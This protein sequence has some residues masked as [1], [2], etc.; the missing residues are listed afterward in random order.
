V[1]KPQNSMSA[2]T[3]ILA[4]CALTMT[5][6]TVRHEFFMAPTAQAVAPPT[7][8][9]DW[10]FLSSGGH[11][12]GD[13]SAPVTILEFAD[14][15][16]AYCRS[17]ALGALRAVRSQ[18]GKDVKVVF[19][20]WPLPYHHLAYSAARAA[21]CAASQGR[22]EAYHDLL[23]EHQDSLG[24]IAFGELA[25]RA[26]VNDSDAFR[27]CMSDPAQVDVIEK[28]IAAA[29]MAGGIGTPTILVSGLLLHQLP[30]TARL[31]ELVQ[32]ALV[33]SDKR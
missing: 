24:I 18:F 21:E 6:I 31:R 29:K 27:V 13:R 22:F 2:V 14:F 15:Q 8:V 1:R 26:G 5:G 25:R 10:D 12:F 32:Q 23:F 9:G 20:H 28:D 30:D 7:E 11:V 16:C 19:R 4:V 17:F 3:V 33:R